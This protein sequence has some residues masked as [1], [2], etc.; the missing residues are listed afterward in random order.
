MDFSPVKFLVVQL[1]SRVRLFATPWIAARQPSLSFTVSQ[2]L[3]KFMSTE[4]VIPS[5]HLIFCHPLLR[6]PSVLPSPS[7]SFPVN[8][9]FG[10]GGHSF[11]VQARG[12]AH[13]CWCPPLVCAGEW[14]AGQGRGGCGWSQLKTPPS[15]LT[16]TPRASDLGAGFPF[17]PLPLGSLGS[18]GEIPAPPHRI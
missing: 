12:C 10:S 2:S 4:S 14:L 13:A 17:C 8:H 1:L 15:V 7:Q 16:V 18:R 5:N 6:L 9:W 11:C 3:L